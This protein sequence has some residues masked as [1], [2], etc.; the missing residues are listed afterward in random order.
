MVE[1][2]RTLSN[3]KLDTA[4][5]CG[6]LG[7]HQAYL[8]AQGIRLHEQ[9]GEHDYGQKDEKDQVQNHTEG[10]PSAVEHKVGA[11]VDVLV[12][13]KLGDQQGLH[14]EGSY[15][16]QSVQGRCNVRKDW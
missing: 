9:E 16:G 11:G 3:P 7:H 10:E 15:G 14:L 2:F 6:N 1:H 12:L 4:G 13:F 5:K 8:I